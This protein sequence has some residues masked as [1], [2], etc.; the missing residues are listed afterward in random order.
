MGGSERPRCQSP[1]VRIVKPVMDRGLAVALSV[2]L[3]PLLLVV[4]LAVRVALG[5]PV[6]F[7][8]TRVGRAGRPF[9]LYKFRSMRPDRRVQQLPYAGPDRRVSYEATND[10][11]HTRLG[12]F[13]RAW[14]LDE[15]PQLWNVLR[16]DMSLVGPR[17]EVP[18]VV[19]GYAD[20]Q[21]ERHRVRPG[22]TGLWQVT[23]RTTKPMH[24]VANTGIDVQ[25]VQRVSLRLDC[26][27]LLRTLP[28]VLS[29]GRMGPAPAPGLL[30]RLPDGG[31]SVPGRWS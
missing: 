16:G 26:R 2:A 13:L 1:Y 8:Q 22:L 12:L 15:L 7:T 14:S 21:H 6:L 25:Y 10:P 5:A 18:E 30:H 28:A 9:T 3:A 29:V 23:A 4:A 31:R 20:W 24:A 11:R 27:I 19:A 17:P